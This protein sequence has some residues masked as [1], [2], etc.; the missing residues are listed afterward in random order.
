[1]SKSTVNEI[2]LNKIIDLSK[3]SGKTSTNVNIESKFTFQPYIQIFGVIAYILLAVSL[4]TI[5]YFEVSKIINLSK[6]ISSIPTVSIK[7][8][9]YQA[10][11]DKI[12]E[13]TDKYEIEMKTNNTYKLANKVKK[14]SFRFVLVYFILG[15]IITIIFKSKANKGSIHHKYVLALM[16]VDFSINLFLIS[17]NTCKKLLLECA[18]EGHKKAL[19]K[20]GDYY[21]SGFIKD[22]SV[23]SGIEKAK[24]FYSMAFP[25]STAVKKYNKLNKR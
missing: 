16:S 1:M 13:I 19:I 23:E 3:L 8:D 21:A 9:E 7:D 18:E 11:R 20:L 24:E 6:E 10:Y 17:H 2:L 4:L 25:D 15:R 14:Y 22:L 5:V 12:S